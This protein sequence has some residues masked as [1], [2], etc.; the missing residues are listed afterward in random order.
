MNREFPGFH[1]S[2][3]EV[4]NRKPTE[5]VEEFTD[6]T[7]FT[8]S[9]MGVYVASARARARSRT[10]RHTPLPFGKREIREIREIARQRGGK[11]GLL[12]PP[13]VKS[14]KSPRVSD[15]EVTE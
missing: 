13:G 4:G 8:P 7:D 12:R 11:I 5:G 2:I 6:F 9:K 15:S 10:R 3:Y 1:T 14:V